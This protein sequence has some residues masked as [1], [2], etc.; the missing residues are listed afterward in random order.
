[1]KSF[2]PF[3][4]SIKQKVKIFSK[5]LHF[6]KYKSHTG[7]KLAL[8]IEDVISL[9]IF[10]QKN[11]IATK[12]SIYNIF[13]LPCSYKTLVVNMNR[14]FFLATIILVL[15]IKLNRRNAHTVKHIDSTDIPV[16]LF[17]NAHHH[18][19]MKR[20]AIATAKQIRVFCNQMFC[21]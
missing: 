15:L 17:K 21:S 1:M 8:P 4:N 7:R 11:N 10:K 9:A 12:K 19:T 5:Q 3:F 14:W 18:K 2:I 6:D 20:F 13:S 16:C